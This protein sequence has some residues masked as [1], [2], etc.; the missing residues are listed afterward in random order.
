MEPPQMEPLDFIITSEV[1]E[2]VR[3]PVQLAFNNLRR[4]I[5]PGGC[6]IFT[7]PWATD[8]AT[9]EHFPRLYDW[10]LV[11]L[12][13]GY[14]L[15]NRTT[16]GQLET[17]DDL[18]FHGG[19][20]SVLEMRIFSKNGLLANCAA[21]GFREVRIAEDYAEFGIEWEE[22]SRGMILRT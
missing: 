6:V 21:A 13:S 4:L 8:G 5:K 14:V 7:T 19:P 15:L 10:R 11:R 18:V 3:L 2:H 12:S 22:C 9:T 17:F 16:E 1:F 20:G